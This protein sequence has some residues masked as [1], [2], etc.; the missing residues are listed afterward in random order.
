[1]D[2]K[3]RWMPGHAMDGK[4]GARRVLAVALAAA[5]ACGPLAACQRERSASREPTPLDTSKAGAVSGEVRF[6]GAAPEQKL[7]DLARSPDCAAEH[8]GPVYAADVLVHEG[9][10]ENALVYVKEGLGDRVFAVPEIPVVI[11]QQAC[12]FVPRVAAAQVGQPVRFLNS[13]PMFHNVRGTPK[14]SRGWN[15]GMMK[16]GSSTVSVGAR[17]AVIEI[18]CDVHPW[19][20]AYLAVFDH[21]YFAVTGQ[22]G[23]FTLAGLPAGSYV[24]EVWHERLGTR[25][26]S[27]TLGEKDTK[28]VVFVLGGSPAD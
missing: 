24:I 8:A 18:L 22:D 20:K 19:M 27:L 26:T 1:M 13:D 6:V 10:V 4:P 17:E 28:S 23:G 9:R 14:N 3:T 15:V 2:E 25:T 16:G 5:I 12:L 11:D 7:L 21:P